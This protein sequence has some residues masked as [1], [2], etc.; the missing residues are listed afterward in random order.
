M[1]NPP[2]FAPLVSPSHPSLARCWGRFI[3]NTE[4][5]PIDW[6]LLPFIETIDSKSIKFE[7]RYPSS[8][9]S[10]P[11]QSHFVFTRNSPS[12]HLCPPSQRKTTNTI[13]SSARIYRNTKEGM[14]SVY[15]PTF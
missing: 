11:L 10:A 1:R 5:F 4:Q 3:R 13:M 15:F 9:R 14:K 7:L 12:T 8:L 6:I 2:L